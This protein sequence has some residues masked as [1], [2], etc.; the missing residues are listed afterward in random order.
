MLILLVIAGLLDPLTSKLAN[1]VFLTGEFIQT[2]TWALTRETE[3]TTGSLGLAHPNLFRLEYA[4]PPGRVTG[5]DGIQVF[6]IEPLNGEVIVYGESNPEGFLHLLN[7]ADG[8]GMVIEGTSR[9][10]MVTVSVRGDLGGGLSA[11]DVCYSL[12]DSL[13]VTFATSD[14]NGN[15]TVWSLS[16]LEVHGTIPGSFF[17]LEVPD[18][19]S[20]VSGGD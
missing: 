11:M 17:D 12:S 14:V 18:G 20:V 13:P 2:E 19:F 16:G 3:S 10:G 9:A 8:D 7:R 1:T 4:D 5:C 15:E 6:T